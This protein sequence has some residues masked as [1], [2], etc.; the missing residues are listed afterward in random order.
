MSSTTDAKLGMICC[1]VANASLY[2]ALGVFSALRRGDC[3][4][5]PALVPYSLSLAAIGI[6]VH[7]SVL[8]MYSEKLAFVYN[9]WSMATC[10]CLLP[11]MFLG[12]VTWGCFV[13]LLNRPCWGFPGTPC[14]R[15][16]DA[17]YS[18]SLG[19]TAFSVLGILCSMCCI[20][21][22]LMCPS[23]TSP[24]YPPPDPMT[25]YM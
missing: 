6:L 10:S 23:E 24:S 19:M 11:F 3:E 25:P 7:G 17:F 12:V 5:I 20:V 4:E 21:P 13:F 9:S 18:A 22:I 15:C 2:L 14:D 16:D 1:E 8:C